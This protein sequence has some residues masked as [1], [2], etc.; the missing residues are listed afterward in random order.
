M[1]GVGRVADETCRTREAAEAAIAK[2]RSVRNEVLSHIA[3]FATRAD[4]S[5][6][7]AVGMLTGQMWEMIAQIEAQMSRVA[8]EVTERLERDIEAVAMSMA[9]P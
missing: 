9:Q 1:S 6:S 3:E 7:S 5:V 2:A 4:K 8:K